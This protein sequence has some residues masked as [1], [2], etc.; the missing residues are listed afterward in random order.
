MGLGHHSVTVIEGS[1]SVAH[2]VDLLYSV[3]LR[4]TELVSDT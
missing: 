4:N 1:D 3:P 2:F